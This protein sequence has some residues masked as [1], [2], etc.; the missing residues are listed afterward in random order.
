MGENFTMTSINTNVAANLIANS[1]A[2]NQHTMSKS[3]ERLSSGTRI[4]SASKNERTDSSGRNW[5]Q[6]IS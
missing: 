3:L 1:L 6:Y 4:N 2:Q 5:N